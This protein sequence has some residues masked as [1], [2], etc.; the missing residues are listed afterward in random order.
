MEIN[1]TPDSTR[2]YP[3]CTYI[4]ILRIRILADR[5]FAEF[6]APVAREGRGALQM[7]LS[8]TLPDY[9]IFECGN[10]PPPLPLEF[11]TPRYCCYRH[12]TPVL[13]YSHCLVWKLLT[14]SRAT[15]P[16]DQIFV[17]LR[18]LYN[19]KDSSSISMRF[20]IICGYGANIIYYVSLPK[21]ND[22]GIDIFLLCDFFHRRLFF[23]W[24]IIYAIK[25]LNPFQ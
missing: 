17:D 12:D 10:A 13:I 5:T 1:G 11:S 22:R 23:R 25:P 3:K 21:Y 15:V 7:R 8:I 24:P 4:I 6:I 16:R 9:P 2:V 19:K 20:C 14:I 18:T